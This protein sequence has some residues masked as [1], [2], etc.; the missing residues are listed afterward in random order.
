MSLFTKLFTR[1]PTTYRKPQPPRLGLE[2]LGERLVPTTLSVANGTLTIDAKGGGEAVAVRVGT[3]AQGQIWVNVQQ[4]S[5]NNSYLYDNTVSQIVF[6]GSDRA[7]T[8]MNNTGLASTAYG[9]GGD[10]FLQGGSFWDVLEGGDGNDRL[11]G[12]N[13]TDTLRGNSG[14]DVLDGGAGVDLLDGGDGADRMSGGADNDY[15]YGRGGADVMYGDAGDDFVDAGDGNDVVYGRD[16]NDSLYGRG[17][18]DVIYGDAGDDF[19]DAGGGNDVVYGGGG[20]DSLYGN[21]GNDRL[22]GG[23][24]TDQLYGGDGDDFLDD[25][26]RYSQETAVGGNGTDWNADVVAVNGMT[27][28]DVRQRYSDTCSF[29]ASLAGLART[30]RDFTQQIHYVGPDAAGVPQYDIQFY[31]LRLDGRTTTRFVTVGFDG[32]RTGFDPGSTAEGESWVILMQRAWAQIHEGGV[33][34]PSQALTALTGNRAGTRSRFDDEAFDWITAALANNK[35]VVA[36]TKSGS[37]H[38]SKLVDGHAYTVVAV[39]GTGSNRYVQLRNP[40]GGDGDLVWIS[41][42]NFQHDMSV[43]ASV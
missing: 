28:D 15:L 34:W 27:L 16:G 36:G 14:A 1:K 40:W 18:A 19:V 30:G 8:F 22:F 9:R 4:T 33:A 39:K 13:G 2:S 10:D 5:G 35:A 41:W 24:G 25:G 21:E 32:S 43:V 38:S 42:N 17:G 7:D 3:A 12:G 29:L 6:V 11:I 26:D 23:H 37:L 20:N 31:E